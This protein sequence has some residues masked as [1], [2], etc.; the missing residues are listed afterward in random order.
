MSQQQEIKQLLDVGKTVSC[1]VVIGKK[2][3]NLISVK[4]NGK[5]MIPTRT[6]IATKNSNGS[7][8]ILSELTPETRL[9]GVVVSTHDTYDNVEL[10]C[11]YDVNGTLIIAPAYA[12]YTAYSDQLRFIAEKPEWMN[13][14]NEIKEWV[15]AGSSLETMKALCL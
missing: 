3:G 8:R 15:T 13:F 5:I 4:D 11:G 10:F 6:T 12:D 2:N 14:Q 7:M 1:R 9:L